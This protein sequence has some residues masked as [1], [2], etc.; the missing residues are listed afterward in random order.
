MRIRGLLGLVIVLA[1][2]LPV[3]PARA[4]SLVPPD[5]V[6]DG[7]PVV[8]RPSSFDLTAMAD[9][10]VIARAEEIVESKGNTRDREGWEPGTVTLQTSRTLK[11]DI[12]EHFTLTLGF[13]FN[14]VESLEP[15][16]NQGILY[17]GQKCEDF[18]P[19]NG[20]TYI[21][22]LRKNENNISI[23]HLKNSQIVSLY[24]DEKPF[25][26]N[27]IELYLNIQRGNSTERQL[28]V[29]DELA[30]KRLRQDA[31][32]EEQYQARHMLDH[33]RSI[34]PLMPSKHLIEMYTLI[35]QKKMPKWGFRSDI[36]LDLSPWPDFL[37]RIN[38]EYTKNIQDPDSEYYFEIKIL[39][40]LAKGN[41]PDA[42]EIFINYLNKNNGVD[43]IMLSAQYF[44]ASGQY[45]YINH[46]IDNYF[47]KFLNK[48]KN[49]N[50]YDRGPYNFIVE[51]VSVVNKNF[52][53]KN[54][55]VLEL[56]NFKQ[57]WPKI[58]L[59]M[60]MVCE[61]QDFYDTKSSQQ[62][63]LALSTSEMVD[64]ADIEYQKKVLI[65]SYFKVEK[66]I[67][68]AKLEIIDMLEGKYYMPITLPYTNKEYDE[69]TGF[70]PY[71]SLMIA[72]NDDFIRKI[73]NILYCR[74]IENKK[75]Y[76]YENSDMFYNIVDHYGAY[77]NKYEIIASLISSRNISRAQEAIAL[78]ALIKMYSRWV[79]DETNK[80]YS[81]DPINPPGRTQ[82]TLLE[83]V[84]R[85]D[86]IPAEPLTCP[87]PPLQ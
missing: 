35:S 78:R 66:V 24:N 26:A 8:T 25:L 84:I 37:K 5:P 70:I 47:V 16:K 80:F 57:E 86:K 53:N 34:S 13:Q 83:A 14:N 63:N 64:K 52:T 21:L 62:L 51:F 23:L 71:K 31:T 28:A 81:I 15:F 10:I 60:L 38:L 33:L 74:K 82:F 77:G 17:N 58:V 30:Q 11:G 75:E 48:Q 4:L 18:I 44:S 2:W 69:F 55:H 29:L 41:H 32:E 1:T 50:F 7:E 73:I 12:P 39:N 20:K 9:A 68:W 56:Q 46:I 36:S 42:R 54:D 3:L 22:Y 61:I 65:L 67:N 6:C 27:L 49:N 72:K 43:A 76:S 87:A 59:K 19:E 45:K 85:G 79:Q 40:S